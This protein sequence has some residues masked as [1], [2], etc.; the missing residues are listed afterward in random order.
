MT[1]VADSALV[2]HSIGELAIRTRTGASIVAVLRKGVLLPNP[3]PAEHIIV[4]DGLAVLGS[5]Q[6]LTRFADL[7]Q[8]LTSVISTSGISS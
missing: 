5:P 3:E 4:S 8:T 1:V 7:S 6:Q 2:G